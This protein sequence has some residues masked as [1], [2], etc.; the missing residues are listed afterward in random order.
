MKMFS[1]VLILATSLLISP[2][3]LAAESASSDD[4]ALR[5]TGVRL[6]VQS[7]PESEVIYRI[8]VGEIAGKRGNLAV[9]LDNYRLAAETSDD[10]R[11]AERATDIALFMG[12]DAVALE[13]SRRWHTLT[14]ESLLARQSLALALLRNREVAEAVGHLDAMRE[15]MAENDDGGFGAINAIL[16]QV[17][18]PAVSAQVM[19]QLR[20]RYPASPHALFYYGLAAM[21]NDNPQAALEAL[22]AAV[23]L[24]PDWS[25][26]HLARAELLV[27]LDRAGEALEDL[28]ETVDQQPEA[29][30][31]RVGYARL[32]IA[33]DQL[34]EAREQFEQLVADDPGDGDSLFALGVLAAEAEQFDLAVEYLQKVL[35]LDVR[36]LDTYYELGKVEELRGNFE[37][38]RDWYAQIT[39]GDRYLNAQVRVATMEARLGDF[40][41][42]AERFE[43]LRTS[44]PDSAI[45]LYIAESEVLREEQRYQM[46]F[47][48][49][50]TALH[51]HP[52]NH[53]LLYSRALIAERLDRLDVLEQ[54]LH[55]IIE[56]DPDN[57]HA[58][59]ALGYTLAD[60][61][62]RYEEALDYIQQA[63][64]LL[65]EDAAVLD[66]MGWVKY[67]LEDYETALRY[68]REAYEASPDPE[69]AAHLSEVLWVTGATD[70]ARAV[71]QQSVEEHPEDEHLIEVQER[72]GL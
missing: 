1:K 6:G 49:L 57:G 19:S 32:L 70:E 65:P 43:Q 35:A 31:L 39:S 15:Q 63:L 50:D 28:A 36:M 14:P 16:A 42:M 5:Q 22:S 52:D 8:L 29:R 30:P 38:A 37:Q 46:S 58:L 20:D 61:T 69:I 27:Q 45:V 3:V 51:D 13:T 68:L 47:D 64:E 11:I 7:G 71:W 59:N 21:G 66:S 10:P 23:K 33:N 54:D 17:P 53:D 72:F 60:R 25:Q 55:R 56:A 67:R 9:A 24:Q 41:A 40:P 34:Q 2:L 26:A 18:D 44:H 12:E 4:G 62:D 48:L